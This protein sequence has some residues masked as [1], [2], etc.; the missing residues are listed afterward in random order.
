VKRKL[1]LTDDGSH[2]LKVEEL[3]EHYHSTFGAIAESRHVFIESG[4]DKKLEEKPT[5]LN[6]LE[7]GFGT[8]LNALLT[9]L[10]AGTS[11]CEVHYV[12]LEAYPLSE[13]ILKELNY[14]DLVSGDQAAEVFNR[15]HSIEWGIESEV[16]PGFNLTKI[17]EKLQNYQENDKFDLI[18]FDAFG[19]DVQPELW[20]EEI[21]RNLAGMTA[22]GGILVTY[23]CKG[24]V[25]RALKAAGF[26][27][28]KI[29]G[30]KGKREM[31]RGVRC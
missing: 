25:K 23:S 18:Y 14:P 27:I 21:F 22:Y 29:P 8:G 1:L 10:E 16:M 11:D 15:I 20:N 17:E 13:E 12:G 30:P 28:E 31:L 6:L 7:V 5:R 3:S 2:T 19:P 26:R 4:F 24:T 9:V